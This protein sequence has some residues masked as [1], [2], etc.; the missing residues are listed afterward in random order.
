MNTDT[1]GSG[2]LRTRLFVPLL[3]AAAG[4]LTAVPASAGTC[5]A[6]PDAGQFCFSSST[7]HSFCAG[8]FDGGKVC[9]SSLDC[10]RTCAGG[11]DAGKICYGDT[12][13]RHSCSGGPRNGQYCISSSDCSGYY[14]AA[15]ACQSYACQAVACIGGSG[16]AADAGSAALFLDQLACR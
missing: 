1:L 13:C 3:L 2:K 11:L 8:G 6:G 14:C 16:F 12:D 15:Y 5:A 10:H 4:L 9:Y 7:C